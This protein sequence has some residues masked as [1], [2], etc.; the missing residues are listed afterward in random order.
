MNKQNMRKKPRIEMR[1]PKGWNKKLQ[2]GCREKKKGKE[3][4]S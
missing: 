2:V 3:K 1:K 4:E